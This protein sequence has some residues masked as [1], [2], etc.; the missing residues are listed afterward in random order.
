V[1]TFLASLIA[2]LAVA[3][4]MGVGVLFGRRSLR[5]SCGGVG[6]GQ[7]ACGATPGEECRDPTQ[8][9]YTGSKRT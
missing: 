8:A 6:S 7:C 5:G 4:A 3:M 9:A 2:F 1:E